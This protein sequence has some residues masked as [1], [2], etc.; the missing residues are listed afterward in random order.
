MVLLCL[1]ICV[2]QVP[3]NSVTARILH[4]P[5]MESVLPSTYRCPRLVSI[6]C[7]AFYLVGC[8]TLLSLYCSRWLLHDSDCQ[9]G[10]WGNTVHVCQLW[11]LGFCVEVAIGNH[12]S[13]FGGATP[14]HNI[15]V[16]HTFIP[17]FVKISQ[18]M[19][20]TGLILGLDSGT[21]SCCLI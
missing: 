7:C 19:W 15:W 9:A 17:L 18:S 12:R 14:W 3:P 16:V 5:M 11:Y 20:A 21:F 8:S 4:S 1:Y 10:S 6:L 2:E 13:A